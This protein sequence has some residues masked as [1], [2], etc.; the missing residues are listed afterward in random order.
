VNE[1]LKIR[2]PERRPEDRI[3]W[4]FEKYGV[5]SMWSTYH[6]AVQIDKAEQDHAE[7]SARLDGSRP[8]FNM[9]WALK[10]PPKVR[11]FA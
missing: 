3:A 8:M 4:H 9:I 10:A 2:L 11:V 1:V 6:L 5:F 7:C